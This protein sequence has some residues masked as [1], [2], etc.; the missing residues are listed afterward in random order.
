MPIEKF[1]PFKIYIL[2]FWWNIHKN[3]SPALICFLIKKR[4]PVSLMSLQIDDFMESLD[5]IKE[6]IKSNNFNI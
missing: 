1:E 2:F 6:L 5:I 4:T 3:F